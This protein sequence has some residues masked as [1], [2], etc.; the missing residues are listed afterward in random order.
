MSTSA[1]HSSNYS[2][3]RHIT[4]SGVFPIAFRASIKVAPR[5]SA[6][7]SATCRLVQRFAVVVLL[8]VH[9]CATAQFR[10]APIQARCA[11]ACAPTTRG[12]SRACATPRWFCVQ[13]RAECAAPGVLICVAPDHDAFLRSLATISGNPQSAAY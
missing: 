12:Y 13:S 10:R 5:S 11:D 7:T 6:L 3:T 8:R 9:V 4:C 1:S 2:M